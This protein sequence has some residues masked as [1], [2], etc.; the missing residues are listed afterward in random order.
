MISAS[1]GYQCPECVKGGS[2]TGHAPTANRPRT[3]AGGSVAADPR[4]VT[5]VILALNVALFIAVRARGDALLDDLLLFGRA[6]TELFGPVE[7]VAEGQ[8]YRLFSSM[9]LHQEIWHI[10][11]NML[12]LWF[13][14]P[15]LEAA[16]GRLR[17]VG[18]YLL[19]GLGGGALTYLIAAPEQPSLGASGAIF[20]LFGATAVL[21][22]R[23]RYDMRPI[24]VLLGINLVF[25]FTWS[26]IAWEAHVG[27]L[28]AGALLAYAMVHAPRER[29]QLVQYA[30]FGGMLLVIVVMCVIR[31]AQLT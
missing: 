16:L 30:A 22:R 3:L 25:T 17:F 29:R 10:L 14:G 15:P 27:G 24:L 19:S 11:M 26:N 13:L 12:G 2:G 5:K 6:R 28:V 20:G 31:T 21:M 18:L 7:G 23:L 4:L 1:V 9:F 8:W